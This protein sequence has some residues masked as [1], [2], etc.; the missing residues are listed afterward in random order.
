MTTTAA[1]AAHGTIGSLTFAQILPRNPLNPEPP[2]L[3]SEAAL[4]ALAST[5]R[6]DA[7]TVAIETPGDRRHRGAADAVLLGDAARAHRLH[8]LLAH[9][10][11]H[12][13]ELVEEAGPDRAARRGVLPERHDDGG[14]NH[15][16]PGQH[17]ATTQQI[18]AG[19]RGGRTARGTAPS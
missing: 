2:P 3:L 9:V 7:T 16:Q 14:Q 6:I 19:A 10:R 5:A 13:P 11:R 15:D 4:L 8:R 1:S 12:Q 17:Q 18:A